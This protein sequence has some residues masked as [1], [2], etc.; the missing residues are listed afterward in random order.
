ML[1]LGRGLWCGEAIPPPTLIHWMRRLP[2]VRFTNLY[3]PTETTIASSCYTVPR[4]PDAPRAPIP[5]GSACEGEELLVL[6]AGLRPLPAGELIDEPTVDLI[7]RSGIESVVIR[8]VLTCE[9]RRG[10]G[11]MCYGRNMATMDMVDM[12]HLP[13][14]GLRPPGGWARRRLQRL[15]SERKP[16]QTVTPGSRRQGFRHP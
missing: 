14:A 15:R 16:P 2:R 10:V 4:C 11:R 9:A 7:D 6:D 8:S 12:G 5:I 1:P 13:G 3:G